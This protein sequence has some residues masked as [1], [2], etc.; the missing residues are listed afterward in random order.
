MPKDRYALRGRLASGKSA[1]A[2]ELVT[3]GLTYVNFTDLLKRL[4]ADWCGLSLNAVIADKEAHRAGIIA[5]G[6]AIDFDTDPRYVR[7]ALAEA[8]HP[9]RAVFDNV[10]FPAQMAELETFGYRLVEVWCDDATQAARLAAKGLTPEQITARRDDPTEHAL[11]GYLSPGMFSV[12]TSTHTPAEAAEALLARGA[13]P[14][15]HA[16]V[17][18]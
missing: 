14:V 6:H 9:Y 18:G 16:T 7:Q 1:L 5:Y 17:T 4:Y 8:G 2:L 15:E 11:D 12:C 3:R 10:R 13:W